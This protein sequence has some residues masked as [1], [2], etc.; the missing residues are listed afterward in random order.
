[1]RLSE[2]YD[3]KRMKGRAL[4]IRAQALAA[5]G[6]KREAHSAAIDAISVL[7]RYGTQHTLASMY[8][9]SATLEH[10]ARSKRHAI[11]LRSAISS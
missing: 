10:N 2:C 5:L 11:E 3:L 8:E 6:R 4:G 9:L 1:M 7:E